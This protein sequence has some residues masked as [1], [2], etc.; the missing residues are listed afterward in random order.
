[1][2]VV[3]AIRRRRSCRTYLPKPIEPEK[4]SVLK[5]CLDE[6]KKGPFGTPV[7]FYLVDMSAEDGTLLTVRGTYGIVQGAQWFIVG[8]VE[9]GRKAMEDFGYCMEH[10]ILKATELGLSTCWLG[11]TF[12]RMDFIQKLKLHRNTLLP[13]VS[14]AGYAKRHRSMIDQFIHWVAGSRYRKP[15]EKL[16]FLGSPDRPLK[17]S[18][19]R[20]FE[21]PLECVRIAPSARNKQPWRIVKEKDK[22]VFHF[23]MEKSGARES[24]PS[25]VSMPHIDMG[26]AMCHFEETVRELGFSGKWVEEKP[27]ARETILEYSVTWR[28]S[29]IRRSGE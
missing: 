15:W 28:G 8:T 26:I 10:N 27:E 24:S 5:S 14:P 20:P 18:E 12:N 2:P 29:E 25:G 3:R 16:F 21:L 7:R 9:R 19:S 1:M 6:N 11:V 13:A 17:H 22:P 23:F 4:L